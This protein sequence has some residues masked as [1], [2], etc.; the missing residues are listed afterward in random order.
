MSWSNTAELKILDHVFKGTALAQP[1]NITIGLSTADPT[2]NGS[3]LAEPSGGSYARQTQNSWN[4]AA[5]NGSGQGEV[6]NNGDITFPEATA[7]WGT[8]THVAIFL[9][10][11]FWFRVAL[12]T[13]KAITTG[14]VLKIASGTLKVRQD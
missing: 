11:V 8:I 9:D 7:N 5:T 1:T 13:S 2:D 6:T 12:D 10:N 3:A 14:D 4:A